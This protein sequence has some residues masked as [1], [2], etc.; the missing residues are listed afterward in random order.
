VRDTNSCTSNFI[1]R[2]RDLAIPQASTS[3]DRRPATTSALAAGLLVNP[4]CCRIA[5]SFHRNLVNTSGKFRRFC[6]CAGGVARFRKAGSA[7]FAGALRRQMEMRVLPT[8]GGRRAEPTKLQNPHNLTKSTSRKVL[9]SRNQSET[10]EQNLQ[11]L[12]L[13]DVLRT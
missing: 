10:H 3:C 11:S 7:G 13:E 12:T 9:T 2:N 4:Q 6:S 1:A 5:V 8:L